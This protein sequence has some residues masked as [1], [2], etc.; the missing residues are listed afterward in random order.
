MLFISVSLEPGWQMILPGDSQTVPKLCREEPQKG[1]GG[2]GDC[3]CDSAHPF[4][5]V[6]APPSFL[7]HPSPHSTLSSQERTELL[8]KKGN[9]YLLFKEL[10]Q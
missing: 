7:T 8:G 3:G 5:L 10:G 2:L 6:R 9:A 4:S 1:G